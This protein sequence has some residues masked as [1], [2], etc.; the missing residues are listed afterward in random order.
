MQRASSLTSK[1]TPR[2]HIKI[3]NTARKQ[4]HRRGIPRCEAHRL[5][6]QLDALSWKSD[7]EK[8]WE[9]RPHAV[10]CNSIDRFSSFCPCAGLRHSAASL[11]SLMCFSC[12][13]DFRNES[14]RLG[15]LRSSQ[16]IRA[17]REGPSVCTRVSDKLGAYRL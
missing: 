10:R 3:N 7:V 2:T 13:S 9:K 8:G 1:R 15:A 4:P 6:K 5:P 11:F 12:R 14:Q 16:A 17:I